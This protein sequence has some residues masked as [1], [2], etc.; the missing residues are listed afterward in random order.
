MVIHTALDEFWHA[1]FSADGG[2]RLIS[3]KCHDDFSKEKL[4]IF[5]S[6]LLAELQHAPLLIHIKLRQVN[7]RHHPA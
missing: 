2:K 7:L 6:R 4:I 3:S 5:C 1:K